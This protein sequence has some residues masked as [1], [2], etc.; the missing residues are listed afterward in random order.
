MLLACEIK[1][2]QQAGTAGGGVLYPVATNINPNASVGLHTIVQ[3][4]EGARWLL[5]IRAHHHHRTHRERERE[6][7]GERERERERESIKQGSCHCIF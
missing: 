1:A 5:C 2:G 3:N 6:R 7:E 4:T